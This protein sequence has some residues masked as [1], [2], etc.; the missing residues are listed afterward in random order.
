M[1]TAT[2]T[3]EGR[4]HRG[5]WARAWGSVRFRVECVA[6]SIFLAGVMSTL[7]VVLADVERRPGVTLDDPVLARLPA[8][9]FTWLTFAAV[10]LGL[11][12]GVA[13]LARWPRALVRGVQAYAM[14][15]L[16]RSA[17]LLV[18]PLAA[19]PDM[20]LL[21]DPLARH[22][23]SGPALTKDLFFSGHTSTLFLLSLTARAKAFKRLFLACTAVVGVAVLWQHVHYT[24]DVLAA[25]PFAYAAFA[26]V[27][28]G[29][30]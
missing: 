7:S 28:R 2:A 15:M 6:T 12:L 1:T 18:V 19:P 5:A 27:T 10:Y 13:H 23:V 30:R 8:R 14:L 11:A 9:D 22:V 29:R 4:A 24:I 26:L 17:T 20:I 3:A 21:V 25:P 16:L